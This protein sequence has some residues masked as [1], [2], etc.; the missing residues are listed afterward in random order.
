MTSYVYTAGSSAN[1][2]AN[3]TTSKVRISTT[4]SPIQV[5]SSFPNVAVTGTVTC[6]TG[7][8]VVTGSG[9]SFLTQLNVGAWV[10]NAT[11]VTVGIIKAIANATSLTLTANANVAI[12]GAGATY[13]PYGVPYTVATANSMIIPANSVDNSFIVGKGNIVSYLNV[14]G[15]T[16]APFSITELGATYPDTGSSG[17]NPSPSNGG[18]NQ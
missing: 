15:A 1:A 17:V 11:G 2:S 14:S 13:N 7:N 10:G 6:T 4:S 12:T 5:V 18:P 3:I 8:A 9:T 16:A